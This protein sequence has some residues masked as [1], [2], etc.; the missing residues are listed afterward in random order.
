MTLAHVA[1]LLYFMQLIEEYLLGIK[2]MINPDN[3]DING[4]LRQKLMAK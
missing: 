3:Q 4:Q 2:K 1:I